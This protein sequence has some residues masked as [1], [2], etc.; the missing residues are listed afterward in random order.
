M[1]IKTFKTRRRGTVK[2]L[3]NR[4]RVKSRRQ[5]EDEELCGGRSRNRNKKY[6]QNESKTMSYKLIKKNN[7][8]QQKKI[9][10]I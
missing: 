10:V 6:E 3:K 2:T 5:G 8:K 9:P 4:A 1:R 7:K